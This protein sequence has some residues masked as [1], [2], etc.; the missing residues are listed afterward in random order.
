MAT[1]IVTL[2]EEDESWM[3]WDPSVETVWPDVAAPSPLPM[4]KL[5]A[6]IVEKPSGENYKPGLTPA[7]TDRD[8]RLS[9]KG[10]KGNRGARAISLENG[11]GA[12]EA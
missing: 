12:T 7:T 8:D 10:G 1:P 4:P 11:G 5:P 2:S 3:Q 9:S 6:P